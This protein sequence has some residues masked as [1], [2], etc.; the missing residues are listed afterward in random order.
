MENIPIKTADA[1]I[2][3]DNY[4]HIEHPRLPPMKKVINKTRSD[5]YTWI[6]KVIGED[7][8]PNVKPEIN[9]K[10]MSIP[11]LIKKP[12]PAS[13]INCLTELQF[14]ANMERINNERT[15]RLKEHKREKSREDYKDK[16][17]VLWRSNFNS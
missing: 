6:S 16:R 15:E 10:W 7:I 13:E 2:N 4:Q 8:D 11:G 9:T 12:I 14:I 1:R 3:Y 17:E 5:G